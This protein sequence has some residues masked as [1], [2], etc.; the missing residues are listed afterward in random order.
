MIMS[1]LSTETHPL[2]PWLPANAGLLMCGTFPPKKE[3]WTMEFYYP[4][5]INDMWRIFGII[6]HGD[7]NWFVDMANHTFRL[8]AIKSMLLDLGIALSDTGREIY[9]ERDNASD[10]YLQII[11]PIDLGETLSHIPLCRAIATTGEKAA[12]IVST[13]TDTEVP[14]TGDCVEIPAGR[15]KGVNRTMMHYRMPSSSRAYPLKI[16]KKAC[17]YEKMLIETGIINN[18]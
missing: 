4:N 8:D 5:F 6:L 3:R 1:G 14:K 18:K 13:V 16:E 15:I 9:R 17:F 12:S 2:E 10:K 7:R 11:S